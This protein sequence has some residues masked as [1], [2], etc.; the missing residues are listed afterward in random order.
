MVDRMWNDSRKPGG[1]LQLPAQPAAGARARLGA[2]GTALLTICVGCGYMVGNTRAPEIRTVHVPAF[3]SDSFRRG[4][5]LQLTEAVQEQVQM[6]GFRLAKPPTADTRL[7]GHIISVDKRPVNQNKFDDPRELEVALAVKVRW[8]DART[9]QLLNETEFPIDPLGTHAVTQTTMAP[10]TGQSLATGT[11][12]A[13]D[14][15]ARQIVGM[16]EIPW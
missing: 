12:Q 3:T 10:E 4:F 7:V 5:E 11:Q 1:R 2:L 9:G 13:V 14:S 15:L 16:M 6:R 8:E